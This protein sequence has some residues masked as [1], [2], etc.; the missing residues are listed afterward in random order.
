MYSC[1]CSFKWLSGCY[2]SKNT[3]VGQLDA[4]KIAEAVLLYVFTMAFPTSPLVKDWITRL[5]VRQTRLRRVRQQF[6]M[7]CNLS[8]VFIPKIGKY[9]R[10]WW[11]NLLEPFTSSSR[12][13]PL[14]SS[15]HCKYDQTVQSHLSGSTQGSHQWKLTVCSCVANPGHCYYLLLPSIIPIFLAILLNDQQH[16][17][18]YCWIS[19]VGDNV[20]SSVVSNIAD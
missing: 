20:A 2:G 18:Q 9:C 4:E 6:S 12:M 11:M 13:W 14:R 10:T 7:H 1:C 8:K 16:W 5:F 3:P 15:S 17:W 19:N